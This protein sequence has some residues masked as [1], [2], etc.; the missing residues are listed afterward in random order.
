MARE[1]R[2]KKKRGSKCYQNKVR[3]VTGKYNYMVAHRQEINENTKQTKK[4]LQPLEF[5]IEKI[6][7][8]T[9]N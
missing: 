5:F 7:K 4:P 6:K 8:P 2:S 3:K 9:T 1:G